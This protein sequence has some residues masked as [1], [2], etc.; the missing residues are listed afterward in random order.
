MK[1]P[2]KAKTQ[3]T[4]KQKMERAHEAV[5]EI[6]RTNAEAREAIDRYLKQ[7][8][9]TMDSLA[10][11][12]EGFRKDCYGAIREALE[13]GDWSKLQHV[14]R[15]DPLTVIHVTEKKTPPQPAPVQEAEEVV[16]EPKPGA[17]PH[18]RANDP[19]ALLQQAIEELVASRNSGSSAIDE[20]RFKKLFDHEIKNGIEW[21]KTGV[22]KLIDE[23]I[24]EAVRRVVKES[25]S[26][27]LESL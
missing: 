17:L 8:G 1:T 2:V 13:G 12:S 14:Q 3:P 11:Q 24:N 6:H 20:D 26:K 22:V 27:L 18:K 15:F 23:R 5:K 10:E 25:L 19:A 16:Q 9:V 4:E 7:R 21:D